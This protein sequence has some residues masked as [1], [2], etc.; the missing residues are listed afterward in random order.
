LGAVTGWDV[1]PDE[2]RDVAGRIVNARKC[3]NQR[4]GWTRTEDTLPPRLLADEPTAGNRNSLTRARLDALISAYYHAR[5]WTAD[6]RVP[7]ELRFALGLDDPAFGPL[8]AADA[9]TDVL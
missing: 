4:E 6:G 5:G 9:S 7:Q 2:L 3:V 1:T 8:G